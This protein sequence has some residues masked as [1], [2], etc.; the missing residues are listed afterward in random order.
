MRVV[1]TNF[2]AAYLAAVTTGARARLLGRRTYEGFARVWPDARTA[3]PVV[4]APNQVH[5][6]ELEVRRLRAGSADGEIAVFGSADLLRPLAHH[7]LVDR[8]Q[9]LTFPLFLGRGKRML[10][11]QTT[12]DEPDAYLFPQDREWRR[13]QHLHPSR[14]RLPGS[15]RQQGQRVA[16]G[17]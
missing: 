8:Y 12:P 10:D 16:A 17:A 3:D 7:E 11:A 13:D 1:V 6:L 4:A 15:V 2:M 9:L 5:D 14:Q